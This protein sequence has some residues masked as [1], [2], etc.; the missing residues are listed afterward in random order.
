MHVCSYVSMHACMHVCMHACAGACVQATGKYA[1]I[2]PS[3][4]GAPHILGSHVYIPAE[5][6]RKSAASSHSFHT[7]PTEDTASDLFVHM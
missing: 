5:G 1:C 2:E 4:T 3:F 7:V 6:K